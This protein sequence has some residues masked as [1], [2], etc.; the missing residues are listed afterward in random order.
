VAARP[1]YATSTVFG[2]FHRRESPTQTAEDLRRILST[3]ELWGGPFACDRGGAP[4]VKA[5]SGPLPPDRQGFEF[6]TF[7]PPDRPHGSYAYWRERR[8]GVVIIEDGRAKI[9]VLITLVRQDFA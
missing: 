9:R 4:V 8:D 5:F 3:G 2:P 6:H 1:R 7:G